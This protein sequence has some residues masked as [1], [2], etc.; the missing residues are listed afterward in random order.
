MAN[1]RKFYSSVVTPIGPRSVKVTCS[2]GSVDRMGE[3]VVQSG[4]DLSEF[5]QNPI[6]LWSHNMEQPIGTAVEIGLQKGL[7]TAKVEFA[8]EGMSKKADEICA[9]VKAGLIKTVSIG[10]DPVE[11]EPMNSQR[12]K[13]PQKYLK[14]TLLEVSFVS[15]P[16]NAEA[17]VTERAAVPGKAREGR[18]ISAATAAALDRAS[19]GMLDAL[20]H[21]AAATKCLEGAQDEL[22]SLMTGS[23]DDTG[24]GGKSAAFMS[25]AQRQAE[26][27]S[28]AAGSREYRM[29]EAA[30]LRAAPPRSAAEMTRSERRAEAAN[31]RR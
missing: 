9:M 19:N 3:V 25:K 17:I 11:T 1:V 2:T 24:G 7:L 29:A 21:H 28:L 26:A 14:S 20:D 10:F 8:P 16:A 15:I 18:R 6:I 12:P 30:A 27:R 5:R 23:E 13:G 31:L 4:I 22:D